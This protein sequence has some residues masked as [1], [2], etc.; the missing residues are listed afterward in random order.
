[1]TKEFKMLRGALAGEEPDEEIH[2]AYSATLRI[3]GEISNLDE[4]TA[5]LGVHP[6]NTHCKGDKAGTRSPGYKHDMWSYTAPLDETESLENHI[7]AVWSK[8][9]ANKEYL[10]RYWV[11]GGI[12]H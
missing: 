10:R 7:V 3:F 12:I 9:K 1:M 6:T 11:C 8:F 2:F 5:R 4:I